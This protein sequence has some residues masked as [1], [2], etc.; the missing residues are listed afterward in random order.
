MG[1]PFHVINKDSTVVIV[2]VL[3]MGRLSGRGLP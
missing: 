2:H 3:I 1:K